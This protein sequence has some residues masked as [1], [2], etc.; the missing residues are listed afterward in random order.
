MLWEINYLHDEKLESSQNNATIVATIVVTNFICKITNMGYNIFNLMNTNELPDEKL[1]RIF[2]VISS[3]ARLRIL[4][5]IGNGEACVCHLEEILGY[6]QSYIS[7]HLM[8]LR[9][10]G[11]LET[12]REGRYI[13]Y[14]LS[15]KRMLKLIQEA[16]VIAGVPEDDIKTMFKLE[17]ISECSCP[18]CE[19]IVQIEQFA[20]KASTP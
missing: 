1:S 16:G 18:S 2:R 11:V 8:A 12:R 14:R 7:Q 6:R 3:P 20:D 15:D 4:V 9:S 13:F 19:P 17:K 10:A 5:A